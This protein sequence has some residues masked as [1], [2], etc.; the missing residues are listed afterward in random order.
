MQELFSGNTYHDHNVCF[1][2]LK[3]SSN[4]HPVVKAI[5]V[6]SKQTD[7]SDGCRHYGA[8]A[9]SVVDS[10]GAFMQHCLMF[11]LRIFIQINCV[12]SKLLKAK[13]SDNCLTM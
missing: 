4:V 3:F 7:M 8:K 11:C 10:S 6:T 9:V 2:S 12:V 5:F 1:F 13:G